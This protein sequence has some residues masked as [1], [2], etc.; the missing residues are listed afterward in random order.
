MKW[1]NILIGKSIFYRA[2]TIFYQSILFGSSVAISINIIQ[3]FF[4][5]IYDYLFFKIFKLKVSNRGKVIWLTGLPCSGKT[6]ILEQVKNKLEDA[7]IKV[8]HLDGD[9]VRKTLCAGLGFSEKDRLENLMRVAYTANF[10][11]SQDI[12]VLC[13]FVSPYKNQRELVKNTIGPENFVEVYVNAPV[14]ECIKRD[15]KGM[16]KKAI[17]GEIPKFTGISDP[18]EPPDNA[19]LILNTKTETIKQSVNKLYK[20]I[21]YE[22]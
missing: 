3:L 16:Y 7:K 18:Y 6:T 22:I 5:Y 20:F 13:S 1:Y 12:I 17:A 10:L 14:D 15:V 8:I 11:Q 2:L 21:R 19:D 4:Y 9:S